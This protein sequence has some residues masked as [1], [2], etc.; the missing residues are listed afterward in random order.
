MNCFDSNAFEILP[1]SNEM[2]YQQ[3]QT[4][5]KNSPEKNN[6]NFHTQNSLLYSI[7]TFH[8]NSLLCLVALPQQL[9]AASFSLP[10]HQTGLPLK[11]QNFNPK[12]LQ[13]HPLQ[14]LRKAAQSLVGPEIHP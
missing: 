6:Y 10:A 7:C 12:R 8:L 9:S 1:A 5:N 11:V 13:A 2:V 14:N 3:R 4:S